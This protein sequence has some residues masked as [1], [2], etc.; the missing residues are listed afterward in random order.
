M[1]NPNKSPPCYKCPKRTSKCHSTCKDYADWKTERDEYLAEQR[2]Q[3]DITAQ[4]N[5][6][7]VERYA[8]AKKR[9]NRRKWR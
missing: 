6:A 5:N 8:K 7:E 2:K 3:R 4:L 1:Y 9:N